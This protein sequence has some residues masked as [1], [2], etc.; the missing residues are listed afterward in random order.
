M[1]FPASTKRR[2]GFTLVEVMVATAVVMLLAA[3]ALTSIVALARGSYALGNYSAMNGESRLV[4]EQMGM[5]VRQLS[6][7]T[8]ATATGFSGTILA[9]SGTSTQSVGYDYDATAQTL[10][11]KV[12]GTAVRVFSNIDSLAFGYYNAK[13]ESTATLGHIK[14]IQLRGKTRM[15]VGGSV[16]TTGR[17]LSA[18]FAV[19]AISTS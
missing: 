12:N 7:L 5:D 11:R 15:K 18:Q 8:S 16:S 17:I 10:T 1:W 9:S 13:S 19:R 4:I 3:A 14:Q 2:R 6:S